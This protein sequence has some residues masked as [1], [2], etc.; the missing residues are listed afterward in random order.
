MEEHA[1]IDLDVQEAFN[2]WE[3]NS[4][5][6][7]TL[8]VSEADIEVSFEERYH[9]DDY[10]FD[11]PGKVV[12]HAFFPLYGGDVHLDAEETWLT[13]Q[14]SGSIYTSTNMHVLSL[15]GYTVMVS[16]FHWRITFVRSQVSACSRCSLT[17]WG[18]RSVSTTVV[19]ATLSCT[20][21][22]L[23]SSRSART[24]CQAM[25]N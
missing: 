18:T 5:L 9:G 25:T 15:H 23:V 12:A 13:G 8:I 3:Y 2:V 11:G 6:D 22:T 21:T 24:I 16:I 14:E 4:G 1:E 7:F 10:S 20:R 19:T 17:S